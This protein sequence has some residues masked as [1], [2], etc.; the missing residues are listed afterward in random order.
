MDYLRSHF[1]SD[2]TRVCSTTINYGEAATMM[3]QP[4]KKLRTENTIKGEVLETMSV[5]EETRRSDKNRIRHRVFVIATDGK[6]KVG[7]GTKMDRVQKNAIEKASAQAKS[8]MFDCNL[9]SFDPRKREGK[10]EKLAN[11]S[12]SR[13]VRWNRSNTDSCS[14]GIWTEVFSDFDL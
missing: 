14:K 3:P 2:E 9:G 10:R 8:E 7:L 1:G 6:E 11:A 5:V 4:T 13:E 12:S